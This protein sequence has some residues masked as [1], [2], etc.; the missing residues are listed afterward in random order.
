MKG[1]II[2]FNITPGDVKIA[3][4]NKKGNEKIIRKLYHLGTGKEREKTYINSTEGLK[5]FF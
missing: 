1:S 4:V 2:A 5:E 3:R